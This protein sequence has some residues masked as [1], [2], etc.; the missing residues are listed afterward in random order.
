M[1]ATQSEP[2]L[3]HNTMR[4]TPGHVE[5]FH[6]AVRRAVEFAEQHGPQ[7]MVQVFVDHTQLVAHS[8]QLYADSAAVLRHWSLS[9]P[10][11][12]DVMRHCTVESLE[13]YGE[14]DEAVSEGLASML[15]DGVLRQAGR[16]AVGFVRG[17][18]A[19]ESERR[20]SDSTGQGP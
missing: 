4:I 6:Q 13:L 18:Q 2:L 12:S 5:E 11:I 7:Y 1:A 8:F 20:R 10:Y 14:P 17:P 16:H 19:V 9:D 3:M 15:A